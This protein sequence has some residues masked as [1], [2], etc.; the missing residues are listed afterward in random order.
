MA[1]NN[2]VTKVQAQVDEV[3]GQMV[4]NVDLMLAN[5]EKAEDLQEKTEGL[6]SNAGEFKRM[7][8]ELRKL[9]W[10]KNAK[11]MAIIIGILLLVIAII[12]IIIVVAVKNKNG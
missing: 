5:H 6:K 3:R 9:M 8:T 10:W 4:N 7:G 12:I 2:S 1:A 11:L